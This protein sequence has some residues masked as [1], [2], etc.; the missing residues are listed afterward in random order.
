VDRLDVFGFSFEDNRRFFV[1]CVTVFAALAVGVLAIKRG[2]LGRRLAALRD[3]Q[4]ACATLGLD[5]R[6]TKLLVFCI[7]AAIAGLAGWLFG[8][9]QS[10]VS[11]EAVT[12]EQNIILFL[13]A[14][15]GGVTS[16]L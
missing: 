6:R 2:A 10:T 5:T 4:A 15:V 13:F 14:V 9:L 1:L 12:K 3:S 8:G 7:S 11:A 16:V